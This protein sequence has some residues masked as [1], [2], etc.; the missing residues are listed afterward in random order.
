MKIEDFQSELRSESTAHQS[1][2]LS[3][4]EIKELGIRQ[5]NS[6]TIETIPGNNGRA[7]DQINDKFFKQY[8]A[9]NFEGVYRLP[10]H[11]RTYIHII[12][13]SRLFHSQSGERLSVPQIQKHD[14]KMYDFLRSNFGFIGKSSHILHYPE[15]MGGERVSLDF[16][17]STIPARRDLDED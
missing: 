13:E 1:H 16:E 5:A 15:T 7:S 8:I 17:L 11:E 14:V 6:L 9:E 3:H 2:G 12:T 4:R 10:I